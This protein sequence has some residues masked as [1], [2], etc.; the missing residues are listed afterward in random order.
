M[1]VESL[2][3]ETVKV[4]SRKKAKSTTELLLQFSGALNAGAAQN[5][6]VYHLDQASR[7]KKG[8]TKY[9]K[10][11]ALASVSY[12]ASTDT[13]TLLARSKLN[14]AQPEELRITASQLPDVH[15]RPLDGNDDGQP[16]GDFVALLTKSGVKI[17]SFA[18]PSTLTAKAVDA[19]LS[20]GKLQRV[21]ALFRR[22]KAM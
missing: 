21:S 7:T 20:A 6:G 11:V 2:R 10:P 3:V 5:L 12:N 14:L 8:G 19:L 22:H 4:G 13:V 16:G 17:E 15:G 1:T 18:T 9:N